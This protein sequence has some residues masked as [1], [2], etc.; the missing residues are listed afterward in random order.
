MLPR[1]DSQ[2]RVFSRIATVITSTRRFS[3]LILVVLKMRRKR[4]KHH[5]HFEE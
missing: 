4:P 2:S 5:H 1:A 3:I